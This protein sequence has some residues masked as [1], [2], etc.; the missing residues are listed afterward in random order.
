MVGQRQ[1][2]MD[3]ERTCR[4]SAGSAKR[5][6]RRTRGGPCRSPRRTGGP[7]TWTRAS[8]K[9][10]WELVRNRAGPGG[11]KLERTVNIIPAMRN[12]T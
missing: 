2:E 8:Y 11:W 7:G 12:G 5:A 1:E 3:E 4:T 10:P 9:N 6:A